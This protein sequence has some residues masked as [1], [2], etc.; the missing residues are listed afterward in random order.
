MNLAGRFTIDGYGLYETF[1]VV[2][3]EANGLDMLPKVK[4]RDEFNWPEESGVDIDTT[5]DL[6]FEAQDITL[7]CY[8]QESSYSDAIKRINGVIK[9]LSGDG[10]HLLGSQL[11]QRLY[12]VLLEE[13]TGYKR[14]T[15]ASASAVYLQFTLKLRCP[16]PETRMGS[17]T[18]EASGEISLVVPTGKDFTVWWGD[19]AVNENTLSHT[20]AEAGTYTVLIAGTGVKFANIT[21]TG[22]TI[23]SE[24]KQNP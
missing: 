12:P 7:D 17:A 20:Y 8:V 22:V 18:V 4:K 14:I 6:T 3:Q 15:P 23:N 5:T 16:M 9:L 1:G 24:T 21:G 19:G 2:V 11:R 13:I 10:L